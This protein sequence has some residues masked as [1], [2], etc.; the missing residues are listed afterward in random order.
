MAGALARTH[1][2]TLTGNNT[3]AKKIRV[4]G[5]RKAGVETE[6]PARYTPL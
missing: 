2:F 5:I 4:F 3:P 6:P 1:N